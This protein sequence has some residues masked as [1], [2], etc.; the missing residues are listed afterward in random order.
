MI[1][2]VH[3]RAIL[4]LL[5]LL[6]GIVLLN[7]SLRGESSFSDYFALKNSQQVLKQAISN[8]EQDIA[9]LEL[10]IKKVNESVSYA[11]KI[12]RDRYHYTESNENIMFFGD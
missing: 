6:L 4:T 7:G 11:Q 8:L 10:E 1:T 3:L 12:Y 9:Y 2:F 5:L